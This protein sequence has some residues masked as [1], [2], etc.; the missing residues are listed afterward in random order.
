MVSDNPDL[1]EPFSE[2][3]MAA[4]RQGPNHRRILCKSKLF[5]KTRNPS[6]ATHRSANGLKRCSSSGKRQC[7]VCPYT[8]M[9]AVAVTS[10]VTGYTHTI[11]QP[12]TCD[13]ENVIY[14]WLCQKC[15]HNCK[16]HTNKRNAQNF[17][18]ST[19]VRIIQKGTNYVG[20]TKR[21]FKVRMAEHRD[22]PKNGRFE[23]PSGEHFRLPG[24]AVSDLYGLAIE[25]VKSTDP[26]V[27]KAR[28]AFLI[29]KFDSF[30]NG[31]NKDPGS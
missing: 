20:R 30:R 22:Y 25:N 13:T 19:N 29:K 27:L 16:I 15:G 8:P 9:S 12:I 23:E 7:P 24:H 18:P 5:K 14:I 6:R 31:L 4:L 11:T 17:K 1:K 28:E 26:F 10:D 21:K 2:P 3:P